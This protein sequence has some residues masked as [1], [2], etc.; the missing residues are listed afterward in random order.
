[1]NKGVPIAIGVGIVVVAIGL[2]SPLFYE[3]EINEPLPTAL[4]N[5]EEGLT[6]EKFATM[7]D[8][9]ERQEIVDRMSSNVK[10]MIMEKASTMTRDVSE[11][12]DEMMTSSDVSQDSPS[13]PAFSIL[14]SGEFVGLVGHAAQGTAKIIQVGESENVF[15]R[16]ENFE[17]TN[18]PDL[19]VYLTN[20]EGD[21]KSGVHLEKLKG[22]K[23]DQNYS[24]ANVDFEKYDAVVIY[25]QP[26]GVHFGQANL[27]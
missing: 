8:D 23:G 19:R 9:V 11:G 21:V 16:F 4:D 17:V 27:V 14:K 13:A 10:D 22:S 5:M 15:L 3:T 24:L 6:F 25:C 7:E 1:M 2:A 26:F 18:G 20:S 12:M